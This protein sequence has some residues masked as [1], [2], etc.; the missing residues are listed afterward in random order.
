MRSFNEVYQKVYAE[1]GQELKNIK[2]E[3][4]IRIFILITLIIATLIFTFLFDMYIVIFFGL[5]FII[6]FFIDYRVRFSSYR[7]KYKQLVI[8]NFIKG[9]S[10]DLEYQPKY[11]IMERIYREAEF[12]K[13]YDIYSCEDLITGAL[14]NGKKVA[15]SEVHTQ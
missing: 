3:N 10:D 1:S 12:E 4:T 14:I 15:I 5:I 6:L 8:A 7:L 2:N 13:N 11:G 9:C